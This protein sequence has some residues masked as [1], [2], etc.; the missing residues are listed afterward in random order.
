MKRGSSVHK[1]L[2]EQV[3]VTVP[4]DTLTKED[5]WGLRLWNVIQGLRTLRC[6]GMTREIEVW[7]VLDGQ[8][9]NGIIDEL[10]YDCPDPSLEAMIDKKVKKQAFVPPNQATIGEFFQAKKASDNTVDS[11]AMNNAQKVYLMDVKTRGRA[12]IPPNASMRTTHMQLMVYR[13]LLA[14]MASISVDASLVFARYRLNPE[15]HFSDTLIQ[16]LGGLEMNFDPNSS[17]DTYAPMESNVDAVIELLQHNNL[18][19]LWQL[20]IQEYQMTMPSG[21]DSVSKVLKVEFRQG[22]D[23][24]Y[25][26]ARTFAYLDDEIDDYLRDEMS[27]W[28]GEREARGVDVE[29]AYKCRICE[30]A[31]DCSWRI[32]KIEEAVEKHRLRSSKPRKKSAV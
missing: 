15:A 19:Q 5:A 27:W 24:S 11:T 13:K 31:D 4:V 25:L 7:G 17:E 10:S 1:T 28:K 30:F 20:M 2:E 22:G 14:D 12:S 23:G 26:G 3:H 8:I 18:M 16:Q 32:N 6:T 21:A 29:E 9:V